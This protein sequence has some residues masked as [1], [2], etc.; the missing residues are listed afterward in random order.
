MLCLERAI[1]NPHRLCHDEI[2]D[3]LIAIRP[4]LSNQRTILIARDV[5]WIVH[6]QMDLSKWIINI[7]DIVDQMLNCTSLNCTNPILDHASGA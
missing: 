3:F 5:N 6:V 2:E 4:T 7:W 1:P